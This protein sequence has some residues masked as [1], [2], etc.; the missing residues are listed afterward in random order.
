MVRRDQLVDDVPVSGRGSTPDSTSLFAWWRAFSRT[1]TLRLNVPK[2][3]CRAADG[4]VG[5]G[6]NSLGR[7]A[8]GLVILVSCS[9]GPGDPIYGWYAVGSGNKTEEQRRRLV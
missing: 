1:R 7:T 9:Y 6:G 8:R 5:N 4:G 3:L 2:T